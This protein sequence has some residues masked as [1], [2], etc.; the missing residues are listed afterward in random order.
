MERIL[1]I[2]EGGEK[3]EM[4]NLANVGV[5]FMKLGNVLFRGLMNQARCKTKEV[6]TMNKKNGFTLIELLVVIAIIA[7]LAAMLLPALAQA[8]EKARAAVCTSNQK[9]IGL[10]FLMYSDDFD[11]WLPPHFPDDDGD[12]NP[13]YGEPWYEKIWRYL[14]NDKVFVCPSQKNGQTANGH[15]W[16]SQWQA[17]WAG[18]PPNTSY[19]GEGSTYIEGTYSYAAGYYDVATYRYRKLSEFTHSSATW[20]VMDGRYSET[21]HYTYWILCNEAERDAMMHHSGGLNIIYVDG[22]VSWRKKE[23]IPIYYI[24]IP[25]EDLDSLWKAG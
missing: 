2:R 24:G 21:D 6:C 9:Q 7:I 3:A 11:E 16:G 4:R 22:H 15:S 23:N 18:N 10:A 14:N 20:M 8:R 13:N 19:P 25:F 1:K 5:S 17:D 12:G